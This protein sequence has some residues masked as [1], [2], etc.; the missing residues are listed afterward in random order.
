MP[1]GMTAEI[2]LARRADRRGDAAALGGDAE[3]RW[4]SRHP[5]RRQGQQG[6]RSSRSTWSTTRR[7]GWCS[8]GIPA[9]ARII[10]AG[11]DL[12]TEGDEVEAGRGRR[13]DDQE[14]DRRSN[15][16]N[17]VGND[18]TAMDI[19]KLA[20]RNA[21]LTLSVLM[22][23]VIAG[24]LA[25]QSVP[26]EAEPDVA[27]PIMYV[28][29]VYQGISPED[30]ERLLLR[31]VESQLKS[32]KGLK[33]MKSNAY[34]GGANV[35]RRVRPVRRPRRRADRY[36]QQG[37]GRQ[38]RPA[39]GRRGADRQ[40]GQSFRIPGRLVVTLSGD[41][42]ERALTAAAKNLRDRIEEVP[43]VLEGAHPGLARRTGR[44]DH[45]S[46]EAVLLRA[47]ARPAD[48]GHRR[49]EQPGRRRQRSRARK[50][51]TRSRCRR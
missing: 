25:Y 36:A 12:V 26:K 49:L 16:R 24:A 15:R 22:F 42:P 46:G 14:I 45:R 1:A 8:A 10:V 23:L 30:A 40:R 51:N 11:Q 29:L 37:A 50:A 41:I 32:L 21:R 38:A 6:R 47:A 35:H 5:R 39:A 20:I 3:R 33:E 31:P 2:T 19:V 17:R 48:P 4:R 18:G 9:D 27:I 43:G 44:S 34:Q 13:G 28:S 7:T